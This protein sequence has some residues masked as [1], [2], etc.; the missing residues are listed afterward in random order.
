MLTI[1]PVNNIDYYADLAKEDYYLGSG[2]P[3]GIWRGLGAR[4]LSLCNQTIQDDDYQKLM[5]GFSSSGE[6]LVQNAG[7]EKRRNAWDLTFSCPKSVSLLIAASGQQLQRDIKAAQEKAVCRAIEFIEKNAAITRRGK[8]GSQYERT[9]GLVV[10]TFQHSTNREQQPQTHTHALVCNVAPRADGTWGSIDSRKLY[11]WQ[12]ASGAIYR[13]ELAH[14]IQQLGFSVEPD[15]ESFHVVGIDKALCDAYSKRAQEINEALKASGIAS[16]ASKAGQ[17][18]KTLTRKYKQAVNHLELGERWK[19]D[20][21]DKGL[22]EE[23]VLKLEK[24][25]AIAHSKEIIPDLILSE[26]TETKAI[27]T[28]QDIYQKVAIEAVLAN[29]SARDA[30]S[31]AKQILCGTNIIELAPDEPFSKRYTTIEVVEIE[32][33]MVQTARQLAQRKLKQLSDIEISDA[34]DKSQQVIQSSKKPFESVFKFDDEQR[35]AI[36]SMLNGGDF[37]VTQGSAGSGKTTALLPVRLAFEQKRLRIEGACIA[38]RAADNL[39]DETGI[40]SR[41]VASIIKSID[42]GKKPLDRLD[43]LV[44]D[45][46]GQLPSTVFQQLLHAAKESSCKLILTGE[47]KQLDSIQRGGALRYLSRPEVIGT[48]RIETIRRQNKGW[49]RNTVADLR[50]G[51]STRAL[52]FLNKNGCLHWGESSEDT[53]KQLIV[54]W[55]RYQKANP[56]K[57]TLVMAQKWD[58]VKKLSEIIRGILI[59]EGVVGTENIPLTCSVADKKFEYEFSIGDRVKFTRNEY[60]HLQVSNGT[61]GTVQKIEHQ[62]ND[63]RLTITTD[64][65]RE[66]TFFASEY[67]DELGTNLCLAYALTVYSAQGTTI[68]GNTFTLYSGGMDRANTYVSLSRHKDESHLYVNSKEIDERVGAYD[69]GKEISQVKRMNTLAKL[70]SRDNYSSLAIEHL[71]PQER[72]LEQTRE[73][74]LTD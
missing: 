13:A 7:D 6:A 30:E 44:V 1:S 63:T 52:G 60:Q 15:G 9:A 69:S 42:D 25:A 20:L 34:I 50:D 51:K 2:E 54:D 27:F 46:A 39:S 17:K 36:F 22:D 68:D 53:K 65:Q 35:E 41:T 32:R 74:E 43:A 48:Q 64:D 3:P 31:I 12:K 21:A 11:Q 33:L 40:K 56:H 38:K 59:D 29:K 73:L 8:S 23:I 71:P 37:V 5:R 10:G 62:E 70:M 66:L 24:T 55:H 47:D 57:K 19:T 45:E 72:I 18:I 49:A 26:I 58:D 14:Q 61:L 4:Q 28:E 16:S 67:A